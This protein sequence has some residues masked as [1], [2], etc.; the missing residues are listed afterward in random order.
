MQPLPIVEATD[1]GFHYIFILDFF[2]AMP[3][4]SNSMARKLLFFYKNRRSLIS[5]NNLTFD[6]KSYTNLNGV[7]LR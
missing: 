5:V 7:L 1:L 4:N 3:C 6:K 2:P